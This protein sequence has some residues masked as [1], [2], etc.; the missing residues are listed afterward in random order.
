MSLQPQRD[1]AAALD[2]LAARG[3]GDLA[4]ARCLGLFSVLMTRHHGRDCKSVALSPAASN[5]CYGLT[6]V[7]TT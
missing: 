3:V 1:V 7:L 4:D 6:S 5:I 2:A